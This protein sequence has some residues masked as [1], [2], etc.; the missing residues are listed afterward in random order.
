MK[1]LTKAEEQVM[2]ILWKI[3][4]GFVKDIIDDMPTP[5]PAYNTVST[6]VRILEKKGF[7][8]HNA[9]GKTHEYY[10]LISKKEYSG[11]FL[12]GFIKSYFG[13]SYRQMVSYFAK[14]DN[15][16]IEE[17]ESIINLLSDELKKQ[18]QDGSK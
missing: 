7:V 5:K 3:E 2:Q 1:E 14:E 15:L 9:Y 8:G 10:P 6:I 12:K 18:K 11:K 16:S 17:M 4:K 13:N